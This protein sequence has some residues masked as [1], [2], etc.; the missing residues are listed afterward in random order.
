MSLGTSSFVITIPKPWLKR[1]TLGKGDY[2]FLE[3]MNDGSLIVRPSSGIKEKKSEIHLNIK[4]N[5][6]ENS[7]V[8]RV[9]GSYLNGYNKI[10]LTSE[11]LFTNAQQKAIRELVHLLYMMIVESE[12]RTITLQ[13]LVDESKTSILT[14]IERMHLI[15]TSML[16]DVLSSM[17]EW[18]EDLVKSILS[19]EDDVDQLMYFLLRLI[20]IATIDPS[21]GNHLALDPL[22]CLDYQTLVHRIER[23]ADHTIKLANSMVFIHET[24]FEISENIMKEIKNAAQISLDSF[25]NAVKG[26]TQKKI[27]QTNEIINNEKKIEELFSKTIPNLFEE[28]EN[29]AALYHLITI[30]E[31]IINITHYTADIAELTIDK[32][33]RINNI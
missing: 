25:D 1:N 6:S 7:I 8:R 13:I 29:H 2:V 4:A 11:K 16:R 28:H 19:L 20:R 17:N 10:K 22:D 21:I 5:E 14:G 33:Y 24:S 9:I 23:I 3:T 12:S 18:N 27:S 30:W 31:S 32:T 15:T 26:F